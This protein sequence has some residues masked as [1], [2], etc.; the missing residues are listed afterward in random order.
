MSTIQRAVR[1]FLTRWRRRSGQRVAGTADND[2]LA[3][4]VLSLNFT[5]SALSDGE[6]LQG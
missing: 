2:G 1:K 6:L 4:C 3:E 5:S